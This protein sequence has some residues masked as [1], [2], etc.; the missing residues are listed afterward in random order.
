MIVE[1]I[2]ELF[3]YFI[4][5]VLDKIPVISFTLPESVFTSLTTILNGISFFVPIAL[6]TPIFIFEIAWFGFKMVLAI[7]RLVKSFIPTMGG[8]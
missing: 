4:F 8:T 2:I 3:S 7:V 6:L 1:K 5:F